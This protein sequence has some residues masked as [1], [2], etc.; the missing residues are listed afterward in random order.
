MHAHDQGDE[1]HLRHDVNRA[2]SNPSAHTVPLKYADVLGEK[3]LTNI[4]DPHRIKNTQ[5]ADA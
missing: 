4:H 3:A 1:Y 5:C 2:L